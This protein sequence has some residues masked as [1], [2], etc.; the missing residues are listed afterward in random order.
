MKISRILLSAILVTAIGSTSVSA[1]P[2]LKATDLSKSNAQQHVNNE[3]EKPQC[4]YKKKSDYEEKH[5]DPIERL[6]RKK[7]KV[8]ELY[9][10][11]KI[12]KE[13]ADELT[14]KIDEKIKEIQEFNSLPL[15]KKKERLIGKFKEKIDEKVKEGKLT[16]K[17]ADELIKEFTRRIKEWDGKGYPGFKSGKQRQKGKGLFK[18]KK[19]Y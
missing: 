18:N 10:S 17:E 19:Q 16:R 14:K 9:D 5:K 1:A 12:T 15:D 4:T 7:Q 11:G 6:Q 8:Q 13:E 2:L 3:C